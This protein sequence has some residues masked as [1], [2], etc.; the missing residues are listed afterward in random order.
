MHEVW[1]TGSMPRTYTT[2]YCPCRSDGLRLHK[3]SELEELAGCRE[4][5]SQ[6][7][8]EE[9]HEQ[10]VDTE[11]ARI[12]AKQC[13]HHRGKKAALL[14]D[15]AGHLQLASSSGAE[16]EIMGGLLRQGCFALA[17]AAA[18]ACKEQCFQEH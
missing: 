9:G 2:L 13:G 16:L 17:H 11:D 8:P 18:T 14:Q 4:L 6:P 1:K 10:T 12:L 7:P 5:S 3:L 15:G